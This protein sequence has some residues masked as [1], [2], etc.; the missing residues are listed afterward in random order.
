MKAWYGRVRRA[1]QALADQVER[2]D[3]ALAELGDATRRWLSHCGVE[4]EVMRF[5]D[6][7][8]S[9]EAA[10]SEAQR[11][12][13]ELSVAATRAVGDGEAALR[14][15]DE[16]IASARAEMSP[17]ERAHDAAVAA[18][19]DLERRRA[20][21]AGKARTSAQVVS[22]ELLA[23]QAQCAE[24][25]AERVR[26]S[27][28]LSTHQAGLKV[29][30]NELNETRAEMQRA[31]GSLA[32]AAERSAG[33]ADALSGRRRATLIDLGREVL[34][35]ALDAPPLE[36]E[37]ESAARGIAECENERAAHRAVQD[38]WRL[39]DVRPIIRTW[40]AVG[41]LALGV[42]AYVVVA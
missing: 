32:D 28:S 25:E 4:L 27:A 21:V 36:S 6:T 19:A 35:L 41:G 2:R 22:P 26:L 31:S 24:R 12:G 9:L 38:E 37:M 15:L 29:L 18:Q 10:E 8:A 42:L 39:V 34:R 1:D 11:R 5:A 7:L 16:R 3:E 30:K 17:V 23:V 20:A 33:E 14:V 40:L 13:T